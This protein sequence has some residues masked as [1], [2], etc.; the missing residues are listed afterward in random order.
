MYFQLMWNQKQGIKTN[1]KFSG[2]STRSN[3]FVFIKYIDLGK[4]IVPR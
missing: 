1:I 3:F 4:Q 2:N